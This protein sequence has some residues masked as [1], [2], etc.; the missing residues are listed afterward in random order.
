M[1]KTI[2]RP[3][4]FALSMNDAE[5]AH[6]LAVR[7]IK[8]MQKVP[9]VIHFIAA[10]YGANHNPRPAT[11]CGIPFPNRVGLEAGFDKQ[12]EMLPFLQ[13]LGF[14]FVE[15]GTV[16]PLPQSGQGRPRL[17]RLPEQNALINRFGFNSD[18]A[19]M[20]RRRLSAVRQ[21]IRIPIGISLGKMKDT[22]LEEAAED[23]IKVLQLLRNYGEYHVVNISSPNTPG[24]RELQGKRYLERL[25]EEIVGAE[26]AEA[27]ANG[28]NPKPVFVKFAPDLTLPE[29]DESLEAGI[30]GGAS[31]FIIGNT[32]LTRP[33]WDKDSAFAKQAGGLSGEPLYPLTLK[34]FRYARKKTTLPLMFAGGLMS[35]DRVKEARDS[36][37]DLVQ[38]MTGFIYEGPNLVSA[39]RGVV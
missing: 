39:A 30:G 21:Q 28:E 2:I 16:L 25:V 34:K 4:L 19:R 6:L 7:A 8:T 24:L 37:A 15:E 18:G 11:V 33:L 20:V 23:S 9:A 38:L 17:F 3:L 5:E 36:G 27:S 32:T 35:A 26:Q 1:Y 14:G 10:W 29:I 31:G 22:P 12:A 13:A